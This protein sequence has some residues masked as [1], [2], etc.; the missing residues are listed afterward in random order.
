MLDP[1]DVAGLVGLCAFACGLLATFIW[2]VPGQ[3]VDGRKSALW[4]MLKDLDGFDGDFGVG[5]ASPARPIWRGTVEALPEHPT[6]RAPLSGRECVA[7]RIEYGWL[8]TPTLAVPNR[9]ASFA[10]A[11]PFRFSDGAVVDLVVLD[12]PAVPNE[13]RFCPA[14]DPSV[15]TFEVAAAKERLQTVAPRLCERPSFDPWSVGEARVFEW[16][17]APG[18]LCEIADPRPKEEARLDGG[19][20]RIAHP[21][22][23]DPRAWAT[24]KQWKGLQRPWV[25]VVQ[26][27]SGEQARRIAEDRV[28]ARAALRTQSRWMLLVHA[29]GSLC[30]ATV[31]GL[32]WLTFHIARSGG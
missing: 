1:V 26:P 2:A 24:T 16:V 14:G 20:L 18:D 29:A 11:T 30:V 19:R 28:A 4:W 6:L 25:R 8:A 21:P 23:D 3:I 10:A 5:A 15:R 22:L 9:H 31:V 27:E 13:F 17:V 7:Y 32:L 12:L